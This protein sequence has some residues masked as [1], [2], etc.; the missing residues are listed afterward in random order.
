METRAE[1]KGPLGGGGEGGMTVG[2]S[3]VE[4][5]TFPLYIKCL[6]TALS[7][8]FN[9]ETTLNSIFTTNGH[10][11]HLQQSV[12][13]TS[14]PRNAWRHTDG[15]LGCEEDG[16]K[17]RGVSQKGGIFGGETRKKRKCTVHYLV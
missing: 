9:E 8:A 16:Y 10:F 2:G 14:V 13:G 15:G 7:I 5:F 17:R 1:E 6:R 3:F 11:H 4:E 12:N